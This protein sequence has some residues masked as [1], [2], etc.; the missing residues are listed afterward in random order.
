MPP[1][2]T[3]P[4]LEHPATPDWLPPLLTVSPWSADTLD[5]LYE[6]FQTDIASQ[7]LYLN[8]DRIWYFPNR[9]DDRED[10]F[11]HL[12]HKEN[13]EGEREPDLRRCERLCWCGPVLANCGLPDVLAWDFEE[14][15]GDVKTYVWLHEHDYL[16]VLKRYPDGRR[17]LIT[18]FY[19]DHASYRAKIR[20]KYEKRL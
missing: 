2:E 12:T 5:D 1:S 9:S 8:G 11:W 4:G 16:I 3:A 6:V 14:G 17:R 10:V 15:T 13:A 18:A 20:K 7:A 19:I